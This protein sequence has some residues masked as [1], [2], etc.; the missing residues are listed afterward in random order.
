MDINNDLIDS[1]LVP[2]DFSE[3]SIMALDQ[4]ASMI[5]TLKEGNKITLLHVIEGSN[6]Q[7]VSDASQLGDIN[8]PEA[9]AVEGALIRMQKISNAQKSSYS[10]I[11]Y[12]FLVAGG[13][14]YR[15]IAEIAEDIKADT[16]V[17]GTHGSSGIQAFAGSNASKV[18]Q[19]A[20]CP[21]VIIK[22]LPNKK[23]CKNI[24][25][26]LDLTLETKQKVN[27]AVKFAKNYGSTVHILSMRESDEFLAKRLENNLS[28]VESYLNERGIPTTSTILNA[29]G[30]NFVKQTLAWAEGKDADLIIIMSQQDKELAE[31][32]YGSYSQQ[33]VNKSNIPV[34]AVNPRPELEGILDPTTGTGIYSH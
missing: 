18:I 27:F 9:L 22:K 1:T 13:K 4:A 23:G 29:S 26:P 6:F 8:Q 28:Q 32:I 5:S 24:V 31:Y 34:L 7:V 14:P 11:E 2:I 19:L 30:G 25:L 10:N 16:I 21:V 12:S 17:M 33:I 3:T 20:P 15:K